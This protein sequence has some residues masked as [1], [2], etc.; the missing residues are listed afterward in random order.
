M[1][2]HAAAIAVILLAGCRS[3]DRDP[4][5]GAG[6]G[7][8]VPPPPPPVEV[9]PRVSEPH[10]PPAPW[11]ESGGA[12]AVGILG[13]GETALRAGREARSPIPTRWNVDVDGL[14]FTFGSD[15]NYT[16]YFLRVVLPGAGTQ[17]AAARA[18]FGLPANDPIPGPEAGTHLELTLRGD[19]V[20]IRE[21]ADHFPRPEVDMR[22]I[23]PAIAALDDELVKNGDQHV[24]Y[25]F[26]YDDATPRD[27]TL[28]LISWDGCPKHGD[29]WL[30]GF[31][32]ESPTSARRRALQAI[33]FRRV[34]CTWLRAFQT[35]EFP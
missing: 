13:H 17:P 9:W 7:T 18:W 5:S 21:W 12:W 25:W 23:L 28:E 33:G 27:L 34:T 30:A 16:F 29:A 32:T 22:R 2:G 6:S 1:S 10:L 24:F 31:R 14:S 11:P 19:E 26:N 3:H 4:T 35:Y 20:E 8:A 15:V